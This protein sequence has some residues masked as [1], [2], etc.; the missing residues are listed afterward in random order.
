[1]HLRV[2]VDKPTTELTA[3]L[4]DYGTASRIDYLHGNGVHTL[5]TESCW[6]QSTAAD[7]ACYFDTAENTAVSD[8]AVIT[9]GWRDAAHYAGL[10]HV[11]PLQPDRW[12]DIT[13][14]IEAWEGVVP[15]GHVLG[16]IV[17]QSDPTYTASDDPVNA[18]LPTDQHATVELSLAGS[19]LTL[20]T[21][22][23]VTL[24][25]TPSMPHIVTGPAAGDVN[26]HHR[27]DPHRIS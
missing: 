10:S 19:W 15:A 1:V 21:D 12:Y 6:G 13:I 11:T 7:D 22:G 4:V 20:P 25:G 23:R 14:P 8:H 26:D 18:P 24:A 3:R 2:R 9:R 16:L 5:T 27:M 17:V